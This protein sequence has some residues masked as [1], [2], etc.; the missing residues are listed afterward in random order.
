MS[1]T[2]IRNIPRPQLSRRVCVHKDEETGE[3]RDDGN[4]PPGSRRGDHEEARGET[5]PVSSIKQSELRADNGDRT[6]CVSH[7]A[8]WYVL[9]AILALVQHRPS[10][11]QVGWKDERH[12]RR[13]N[14]WSSTHR[15]I[16]KK[17][18]PVPLRPSPALFNGFPLVA[19]RFPPS[20]PMFPDANRRDTIKRESQ[21]DVS[22][23]HTS[24]DKSRVE[25]LLSKHVSC[26]T[27]GTDGINGIKDISFV[28]FS[29]VVEF[30]YW[31]REYIRMNG[32]DAWTCQ[33]CAIA[34]CTGTWEPKVGSHPR[35]EMGGHWPLAVQMGEVLKEDVAGDLRLRRAVYGVHECP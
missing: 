29:G 16:G 8:R 1:C 12:L 18:S 2:Y 10:V 13:T 14:S 15:T 22:G 24:S 35:F 17:D 34:I 25:Q 32:M 21:L 20:F 26:S 30:A 28:C 23:K 7:S 5:P 19:F 4:G 31:D 11:L 3:R 9:V 33:P 27:V 6:P